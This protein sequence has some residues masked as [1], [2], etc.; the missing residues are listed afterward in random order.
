MRTRAAVLRGPDQPFALEDV[1]LEEPAAGE[2]LVR[3]VGVGLCHTDLF[4]RRPQAPV[5]FPLVAG[6]EGAG[7]VEAVGPGVAEP[8]VGD[9]VVLS[10]DSC[11]GCRGCLAG[12]PSTCDSF[13]ERNLT[14]RAVDGATT[15]VDGAH[16]PVANRW[17]G[18]SS[19]AAHAVVAARNVVPVGPDVPLELL[20][21]L[22][23]G[24]Q[25]GAGAVLE[26]LRVPAGANVVVFGAGAVGL[27]AVMAAK[28]AGAAAVVAVEPRAGRR[29]LAERVGAHRSMD[30]AAPDLVDQLRGLTG[31]FDF[32]LDT[33]GIPSVAAD[34]V[35]SLTPRGVCG[36][37]GIPTGDLTLGRRALAVGRT[38][39]GIIEGGVVPRVFVPQLV[40]LWRQGRFPFDC[41]V[42]TFPLSAI[43]DAEGAAVRGEV[44]KPVLL[45]DA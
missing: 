16:A 20:G 32:A 39:M 18:Q 8:R 36:L 25:T 26:A 31:G 10:F 23:C 34:A 22:G 13:F 9:H 44:V 3:V 6:H 38:V 4:P 42:E 24:V 30:P 7:V 5:S 27:S 35:A 19:F 11:A 14:G 37:V 21:P 1:R 2:V 15:M 28:L 40:E 41:L 17:F 45:V 12:S 43:N 33:T 29:A